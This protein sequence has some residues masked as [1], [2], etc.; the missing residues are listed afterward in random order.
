MSVVDFLRC[1]LSNGLSRRPVFFLTLL[2]AI[3]M[4]YMNAQPA[5]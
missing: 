2:I 1:G 3:K 4:L 5:N